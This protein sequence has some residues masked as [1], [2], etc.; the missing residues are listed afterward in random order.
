MF[1][2]GRIE[3]LGKHTDYCGGES[4]V[5][6]IDRGFRADV[7]PRD[8]TVVSLKNRDSGETVSFDLAVESAREQGHWV[9]YAVAVGRRLARNF[10]GVGLRGVDISFDSNLPRAA[11]LSSST[12][13]V[14]MVYS[15]L[16]TANDLRKFDCF[17]ENI[18]NEADLAEYLGCVENGLTFRGLA[19]SAGVGTFGGSQ[20]HAA[21]LLGKTATL[22]RFSFSPLTHQADFA[23]ADEYSFVIASSGV[24][25]EKTGAA[26]DKYNRLSVMASEITRAVG[27]DGS[28]AEAVRTKGIDAIRDAVKKGEFGFSTAD[29]LAR[30]QQFYTETFEIIPAVCRFLAAGEFEGTGNLIDR[31][32]QNAERL[33]GNQI[34]ETSFLQLSA[35]EIG[36]LAASAFGAGFGGSVYALVH[37]AE[38]E[39]F[40][41]EWRR[42]YDGRFPQ[43]RQTSEF[44]ITRPSQIAFDDR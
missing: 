42:V 9:N 38:A 16:E 35:R 31:S 23:F 19:G 7:T 24:V 37:T 27:V 12:A 13:L 39:K 11:G 36:A 2:P 14:I 26:L 44:F 5:C 20:D 15:A 41:K 18:K 33:L 17:R 21:I 43:H 6:A 4:I 32:H 22:S 30:L 34:E 40:M 25:A 10:P 8:D 28:L 3:F 29:L 1:I